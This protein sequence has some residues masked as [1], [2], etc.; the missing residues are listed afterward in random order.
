MPPLF[1]LGGVDYAGPFYSGSTVER[2]RKRAMVTY[3]VPHHFAEFPKGDVRRG[4]CRICRFPKADAA[5]A[6][7]WLP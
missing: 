3:Y 2:L 7:E 1:N 5:C 6:W 4:L